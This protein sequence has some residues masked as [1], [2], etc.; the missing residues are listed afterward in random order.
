M[1]SSFGVERPNERYEMIQEGGDLVSYFRKIDF[2]RLSPVLPDLSPESN[3]R[4]TTRYE[5]GRSTNV[6][7]VDRTCITVCT[8]HL[9]VARKSVALVSQSIAFRISVCIDFP[10]NRSVD[11]IALGIPENLIH[12]V[13]DD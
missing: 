13:T 6:W 10:V 12:R 9:L 3:R 7:K 8:H 4:N 1:R 5:D 2:S 11:R